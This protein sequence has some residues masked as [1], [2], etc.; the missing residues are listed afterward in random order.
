MAALVKEKFS[1][2]ASLVPGGAGE[3]TIRVDDVVV[4]GKRWWKWPSEET[5]VK[6]VS[7]A[8]GKR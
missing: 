1:I 2:D 5:I 6:E 7:R 4:A 3:F 8:L